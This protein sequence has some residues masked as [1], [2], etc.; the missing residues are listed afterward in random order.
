[1]KELFENLMN[2]QEDKND[3]SKFYYKDVLSQFGTKCRIFT[4]NFASY[5]DWLKP[6]ALE[7]RGIMFEINDKGEPIRI[8][9]RPMEKF[10]NFEET[11]FTMDL[12]L[13]TIDFI[14]DKEDGSLISTYEEFGILFTKSKASIFSSQ[15]IESKQIL[16]N[17][18]HKDLHDRCL[19][20]A[21]AGFTCNF[22]YVSPNNRIVLDYSQKHLFLLNVRDIESGEYVDIHDLQ[23]DPVLRKYLVDI[24]H[25]NP[26]IDYNDFINEVRAMENI[27]GYIFQLQNGLKFKLKTE[28]YS[29]L[30]RMKDTLN[31]NEMLFQVV[32]GGGT[33]DLKSLYSDD[34]SKLKI[35]T[36]EKIFLDY[37]RESSKYVFDLKKSFAGYDRKTYAIEAQTKLKNDDKLELFGTMME[38]F[39]GVS[40][41]ETMMNLN[42]VFL[43]NFKKYVPEQYLETTFENV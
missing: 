26:E 21:K 12:D 17:I 32:V 16:M 40:Q 10:F 9:S 8:M 14:M 11:P 35:E 34:T 13:T 29:A 38:M 6:D 25:P 33:D 15:A 18:E 20:L 5:N 43:K 19:E 30:H 27:E 1:M 4:Y 28:W 31:N 24:T 23:K 7:S 39:K 3:F 2:L 37:L 41:E 22:E 36:F 42:S